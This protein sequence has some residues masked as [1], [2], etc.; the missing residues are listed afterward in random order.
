[1]TTAQAKHAHLVELHTLDRVGGVNDKRNQ[2]F[3]DVSESAQALL[4]STPPEILKA[5]YQHVFDHF[6]VQPVLLLNEQL[7]DVSRYLANCRRAHPCPLVFV[8]VDECVEMN[9]GTPSNDQNQLHSLLRAWNY[10]GGLRDAHNLLQFWLVLLSTSSSATHLVEHVSVRGSARRQNSVPLPTFTAIGFDVFSEERPSLN[11]ASEAS[12]ASQLVTYGRPLWSSL[13]RSDFWSNAVFKLQGSSSF[14][15]QDRAQ[16]FS[17][18]ASRLS[19]GLVPVHSDR[20]FL[21]G[22]QK[23]LTDQLV[24]RHMRVLTSVT[25]EAGM[26]INSPSEPVLAIAASLL[27]LPTLT[28]QQSWTPQRWQKAHSFYASIL[29]LFRRRCLVSP[30]VAILKGTHGELASRIVLMTAW[31]AAKRKALD[32]HEQQAQANLPPSS[33]SLSDRAQI[34]S[35]PVLLQ[36]I[37]AGLATL[38]HTESGA[39]L[40]KHFQHVQDGSAR[41]TRPSLSSGVQLW[42]NFT[43]FDV[44]PEQITEITPEFLWYCWKRGL[45]LQM[46]HRQPGLDGLIPVY[47][48]HLEQPFVDSVVVGS[49]GN[50]SDDDPGS[51]KCAAATASTQCDELQAARFMT[52]VGWE[53]KNTEKPQPSAESGNQPH[54]KLKLAGPRITR[55]LRSP[56]G[57]TPLT[58]RA[59]VNV[60]LDL[61]TEVAFGTR[62]GGMQPR[63][64]TIYNTNCPRVWIR[65]VTDHRAYPC[66]DQFEMRDVFRE[67]LKHSTTDSTLEQLNTL[68]SAVWSNTIN[69]TLPFITDAAA[70]AAA[71]TTVHAE[72]MDTN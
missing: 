72:D 44:L 19:L 31:D 6:L 50:P 30:A 62:L 54:L 7:L 27:M 24:D 34:I 20:S 15:D 32:Q 39:K 37:I 10:I 28:Q 61:G 16:C 60:L 12:L 3:Q 58:D 45:A 64:E 65:G 59:L 52:Y 40:Q 26:H 53:A 5:S 57:E 69:P 35:K 42:T 70:A 14:S 2:H 43:H 22:E 68:P 46:A 13:E 48:G 47:A 63:V 23:I 29:E 4:A 8:A 25:P 55:A 36:D 9:V 67:V 49:G 33:P 71:D 56:D 11:R 18:L 66:L 38:D 21:F 51:S 41:R 17:V 1:M